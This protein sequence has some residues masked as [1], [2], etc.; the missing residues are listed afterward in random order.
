MKK[1]YASLAALL[2]CAA[3]SQAA[4]TVTL[5]DGTP[6][7]NG[8]TLTVDRSD[9]THYYFE[10][11]IDQWKGTVHFTVNSTTPTDF[12]VNCSNGNIQFCTLGG[13]CYYM[14]ENADGT[15]GCKETLTKSPIT[16]EADVNY[17]DC[18]E[19]IPQE[20]NTLDVVFTDATGDKFALNI[21]FDTKTD[22][23]V[24]GILEN[25]LVNVY[26]LTGLKVLEAAPAEAL[27][28]L[29]AGLYIVNGKKIII[30]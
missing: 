27:S 11:V 9:F 7:S 3:S 15:F 22:S 28:T 24:D 26:S 10:G 21:V 1:I 16:L 19:N 30:K 23:G 18:G 14:H 5:E 20:I 17:Y 8:Q 2:F 29:P 4:I 13:S 6:V 25:G 12:E